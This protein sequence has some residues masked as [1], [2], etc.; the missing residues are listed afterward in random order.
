PDFITPGTRVLNQWQLGP[1]LTGEL[2][3]NPPIKSL[4][5]YNTN[6]VVMIPEQDKVVRGL[7]RDDLFTIVSEQFLTDTAL[8]AD[9]VLPPTTQLEQL[10]VMFSWGHLYL[11]L[12]QPAIAPLGEAVPN[13]E[14][15]RR[16]SR[17]MGFDDAFF[18]RS[19][20]QMVQESL[21]WNHPA[22]GGLTLERLQEKGYVRL[23]VGMPESYAPHAQ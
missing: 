19:D 5:V 12:N 10:D 17:G 11:S 2:G 1:A 6:P 23:K 22:L 3:L 18:Q 7:A 14:L 16:L 20:Q 21:D 8:Y 15:F 13:T 4:L 9:I